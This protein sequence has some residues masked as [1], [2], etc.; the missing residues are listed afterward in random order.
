MGWAGPSEK[1]CRKRPTANL[2]S[3]KVLVPLLGLMCISIGIQV[4]TY[5]TVKEQPWYVP[6]E[7]NHD[8]SG[9]KS[10]E[11][12]ALFLVSCFEYIC[13]GLILNPG[14]PFRHPV[15]QNW[16]F[17]WTIALA[18]GTTGYMVSNPAFWLEKLM[19]LSGMSWD[20]KLFLILL[21]LVYLAMAW[22][23]EKA[24]SVPLAR[25]LGYVSQRLTRQAKRRKEYKSIQ[26]GMRS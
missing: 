3:R 19:E 4:V 20:Y 24:L 8:I 2:V 26:E 13:S 15:S 14:P 11:N 25:L 23:Y 21:G 18:S 6:P 10:S 16:P 12:T 9:I 1:L 22:A 5:V 17:I 7:L